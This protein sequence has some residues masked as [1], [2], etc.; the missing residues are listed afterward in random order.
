MKAKTKKILLTILDWTWCLPQNIVGLIFQLIVRPWCRVE[1]KDEDYIYGDVYYMY[2]KVGSIVLGRKIFLCPAHVGNEMMIKH[3]QGHVLQ[4]YIL[5][6]LF[7]FVIALPSLAWCGYFK[8][9]GA[10]YYVFYTEKWANKLAKIKYE[11][12]MLVDA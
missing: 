5:G 2:I 11:K 4:N 3:E 10:H 6:P 1:T 7:L 8:K 9:F 12:G